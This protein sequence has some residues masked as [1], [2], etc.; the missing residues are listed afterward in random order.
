[1]SSVYSLI[2]FNEN[3]QG[4]PAAMSQGKSISEAVFDTIFDKKTI[5]PVILETPLAEL[6]PG[7]DPGLFYKVMSYK[8]R[9][10]VVSLREAMGHEHFRAM[11]I[12]LL[13]RYRY[14]HYTF[15]DMRRLAEEVSGEDLGWFFEQW[16][17]RTDLAGYK[18]VDHE[19]Y[20]IES[21]EEIPTYQVRLQLANEE[22]TGGFVI[23]TFHTRE[24]EIETAAE[25][26]RLRNRGGG[27]GGG[28]R[29]SAGGG[30]P[31]PGPQRGD[32]REGVHHSRG[33]GGRRTGGAG[34]RHRLGTGRAAQG[35]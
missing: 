17:H 35:T 27:P 34:G 10:F 23:V 7:D 25:G 13:T 14:G 9:G 5:Y 15:E 28:R 8:G 22:A 12:E 6:V 1:M 21:D 31:D 29:A 32:D 30:G 33:S 4:M 11:I 18:V 3:Q 20:R 26:Q 24:D 2:S 16:T 19:A